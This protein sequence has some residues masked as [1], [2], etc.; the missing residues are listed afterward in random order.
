[1]APRNSSSPKKQ[2]IFRNLTVATTGD[3]GPSNP[4]E[5][6]R[7]WVEHNGGTFTSTVDEHTTHL[8]A[9]KDHWKRKSSMVRKAM[10]SENRI[11]IVDIA[12][13]IES[14]DS[15]K[16]LKKKRESDYSWKKAHAWKRRDLKERRRKIEQTKKKEHEA[17]TEQFHTGCKAAL[18]DLG[19]DNHHI[20]E[21]C[22]GFQ[23]DVTLTR[24]DLENNTN[25]R[26]QLKLYESHTL[27]HTYATFVRFARP[28]A[29]PIRQILVPLGADF[30]TAFDRFQTFFRKRCN[31]HWSQR[32]DPPPPYSAPT[33]PTNPIVKKILAMTEQL[34]AEDEEEETA[35][36]R[37][38]RRIYG[39]LA[40]NPETTII[41]VKKFREQEAAR[42]EAVDRPFVYVRPP[43]GAPLGVFPEGR[44]PGV[45][46][47]AEVNAGV[48]AGS[49]A[50]AGR[51]KDANV[52]I[53]VD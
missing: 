2:G 52:A 14:L 18:E 13:L 48:D 49:Q 35:E 15:I 51:E 9:S 31:R 8:I 17:V 23:Y 27:P 38:A 6:V 21:D 40:K 53:V 42:K 33:A 7:G 37:E 24:L 19:S 1:M 44:G 47:G 20:Y 41:D 43:A 45:K 30:G 10:N 12:W 36:E 5:K 46:A 28:R 3:L 22:T 29:R 25:E 50:N 4:P 26:H 16:G 11:E 39:E 34:G 32:L